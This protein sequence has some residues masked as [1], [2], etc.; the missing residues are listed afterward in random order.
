MH[1]SL[2]FINAD[3]TPSHVCGLDLGLTMEAF[4]VDLLHLCISILSL[5][6]LF[7]QQIILPSFRSIVIDLFLL[8]LKPSFVVMLLPLLY[9]LMT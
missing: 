9:Q 8:V 7:I 5:S 2:S 1:F 6:S 3:I 4:S